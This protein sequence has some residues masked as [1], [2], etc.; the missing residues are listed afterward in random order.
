MIAD[1]R[2]LLCGVFKTCRTLLFGAI[3]LTAWVFPGRATVLFWT[4]GP[5]GGDGNWSNPFNWSPVQT[6]ANGDTVLFPAFALH[7]VNTNNIP[8]L[9]LNQICFAG[10]GGGYDILGNAFTLTNGIEATNTSGVNILENN[11]TLAGTDQTVDVTLSLT[12]EGIWS[13][14]V[15]VIKTGSGTLTYSGDHN[16]YTGTTTVNAGL[17]QLNCGA[18]F[19]RVC[20]APGH[21]WRHGSGCDR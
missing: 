4:G 16:S 18:F 3:L 20:G 13:G 10:P 1:L 2:L 6:P 12:S 19:C 9:T 17:L 15:G 5:A 21:Q 14:S 8:G 7:Q 11:I